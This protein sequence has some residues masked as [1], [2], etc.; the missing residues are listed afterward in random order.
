LLLEYI[1]VEYSKYVIERYLA[2]DGDLEEFVRLEVS[3]AHFVLNTT[4]PVNESH[5]AD[6]MFRPYMGTV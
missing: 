4:N 3:L 5:F 1:P 6:L 2:E